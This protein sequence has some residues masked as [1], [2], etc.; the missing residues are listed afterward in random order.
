MRVGVVAFALLAAC[1]RPA[2][3][4]VPD[5]HCRGSGTP[6]VLL[7]AG[8]REPAT[9]WAGLVERLGDGVRTC[10][11]DYPGVGSSPAAPGPMTPEGVGTALYDALA[12]AGVR[13]PYVAV[14]HSLAGL[15]TRVLVATHPEDFA[16]AVLF[17]PTPAEVIDATTFGELGWD[18][19]ATRVQVRAVTRWPAIPL[20]ILLHDP[21][22]GGTDEAEHAWRAG[23][24]AYARLSSRAAVRV[25]DGAT[26][27]LYA[28]A[29]DI[30]ADAVRRALRV[31]RV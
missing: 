13:P 12:R 11:F 26:H 18:E 3:Q 9:T 25:V 28:D 21:R 5:L 27:F 23:A 16:A 4:G 6:A 8:G 20:T 29:P 10:A 22:T 2:P 19:A 15:T 31:V 24:D 1:A 7:L 30:A 14:G 17:D